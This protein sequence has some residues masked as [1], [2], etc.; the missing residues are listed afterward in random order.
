MNFKAEERGRANW[1]VRPLEE[2][3]LA[4]IQAIYAG[5]VETGTGSFEEEPPTLDDMAERARA[6]VRRGL[7]FLVAAAGS[8]ILGFAYAAPFRMRSA[9]RHTLEDS[10]YVRP[11]SVGGGV[12]TALLSA[13]VASC[14]AGPWREIVAV[15]GDSDNASSI[16]LHRRCGFRDVGI[17]QGV[18]YKFGRWLDVVLLQ[19]TLNATKAPIPVDGLTPS[20]DS[21]S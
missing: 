9:F 17:L 1:S 3:D 8:Q 12:G 6:V 7:P 5:H 15:V 10:V 19:R 16:A 2:A 13:L 18:G 11:D 14:D 21:R 20:A 4:A